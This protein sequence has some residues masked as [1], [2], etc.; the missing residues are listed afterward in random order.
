M[1][2][3]EGQLM[4]LRH[5]TKLLRETVA[6]QGEEL[7]R[8]TTLAGDLLR[9]HADVQ[10][11]VRDMALA[12]AGA[13]TSATSGD[14]NIAAMG[15]ALEYRVAVQRLRE[16]LRNVVPAT[17][18]VAVVTRGDDQLLELE[19]RRAWHF[20]QTEDGEWAGHHPATS[21]AAV[22]QLET[23]RAHGAS[24]LVI[25]AASRWWLD[26]YAEFTRHL[27]SRYCRVVDADEGVVFALA[28][29]PAPAAGDPL[30][31]VAIVDECSAR[32][33]RRP[34][35][36]DWTPSLGL[37]SVLPAEAVFSPPDA[38]DALPYLDG[39]VD[40]VVVR[41][42]ASVA[43]QTEAARVAATAVVTVADVAAE[44]CTVRWSV[45]P[46]PAALPAASIVV[47]GPLENDGRAATLAALAETSPPLPVI[48]SADPA[49]LDVLQG[50]VD[51][52]LVFLEAGL[53]PLGD[54]LAPMLEP[55][56]DQDIAAVGG[57]LLNFDGSLAAAGGVLFA[58]G[59]VVGLGEGDVNPDAT[60]YAFLRDA[61]AVGAS[62]VAVRRAA[63]A[64]VGGVDPAFTSALAA[65]ADL[66]LRLRAA[67]WRVLYQPKSVAASSGR[68]PSPWRGSEG[69]D[70]ERV[71]ARW[72][73][74][75]TCC[76][77]RPATFDV[78][79]WM[80]LANRQPAGAAR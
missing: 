26:H 25:P 48:D 37:A 21:Q 18:A 75:L 45:G 62:F 51:D 54:W 67:G 69:S 7:T 16:R 39:S 46:R 40:V 19:G 32:T 74:V 36:L 1:S 60:P 79:T 50:S 8:L 76:P 17:A 24:Y 6:L 3:V 2:D 15:R 66:C 55:F 43:A 70:A 13:L 34:S 56:D 73:A 59:S 44:Q 63:L 68:R 31:L 23:L 47:A 77:D 49:G 38:G 12:L 58:D 65:G 41:P 30:G 5:E 72:H 33:G 53:V 22:V 4:A 71:L 29:G 11:S 80:A 9:A 52:V 64:G 57:R 61:D 28:L 42:T 14:E 20:P 35:V 27:E 78:Q 10:S